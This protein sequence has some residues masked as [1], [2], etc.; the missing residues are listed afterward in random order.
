MGPISRLSKLVKPSSVAAKPTGNDLSNPTPPE[1]RFE[2]SHTQQ[3]P[4][5]NTRYGSPDCSERDL[6]VEPPPYSDLLTDREQAPDRSSVSRLQ[7]FIIQRLVSD[8][9]LSSEL[10]IDDTFDHKYYLDLCRRYCMLLGARFDTRNEIV[11]TKQELMSV[12]FEPAGMLGIPAGKSGLTRA[13][14]WLYGLQA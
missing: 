2:D 3:E 11:A 12:I 7:S 6:D 1:L 5:G 14:T 9:G 8:Y 13:R 4:S 10:R